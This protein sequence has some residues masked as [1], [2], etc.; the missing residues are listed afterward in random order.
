VVSVNVNETSIP[1][2][3][4][5]YQNYPNPFNPTTKIKFTVPDVIASAVKQSQNVI[6]K[7][8]DILGIEVA[9]LVN[10]EMPAGEHGV[11]F[12]ASELSSGIYFYQLRSSDLVLTNKMV[13]M[14]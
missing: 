11:V 2:E 5:L 10:Q 4:R 12:D 13:L 7:V 8:Y 9:T 14:R 3:F 6:L 1:N